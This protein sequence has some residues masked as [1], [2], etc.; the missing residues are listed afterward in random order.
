[1][2]RFVTAK[3]A[4]LELRPDEPVYCFHPSVLKAD[5][6]AFMAMFPGKTAY[7]V[8]TNGEPMVL[9]TLAE[10]GVNCFRRCVAWRNPFGA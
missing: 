1:M 10:I 4:A 6:Q 7:A 8:K 5:A 2:Q 9:K 3:A